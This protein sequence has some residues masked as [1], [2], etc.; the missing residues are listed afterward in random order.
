MLQT[1]RHIATTNSS[2]SGERVLSFG[3]LLTKVT[4]LIRRQYPVMIVAFAAIVGLAVVY[5]LVETPKYT[6]RAILV[7]DS[8]KTPPFRAQQ[9]QIVNATDLTMDTSGV[10]TQLEILKS[11]N[12]ALAVIKKLHLNEDPEFVGTGTGIMDTVSDVFASIFGAGNGP[13]ADFRKLRQAYQRFDSRLKIERIGLTYAME[14]KFQSTSPERAAQ[15]ANAIAD[16]YVSDALQAKYDTATRAASW[17]QDRLAKLRDEAGVAQR[18]VVDYKTKNNIVDSGGQLLNEQQVTEYSTALVQA[19]AQVAEA[20]ARLDRVDAIVNNDKLD[21]AA[22]D[23]GTVSDTLKNDVI[24]HLRQQYADLANREAEWSRRY[25]PDH[26]ANINLRYQM[27]AIRR[28]IVDELKRI[29][30]TYKSDFEIAQARETSIQKG[31]DDIVRQ[32][33]SKNQ[34]QVTLTTLE[35]N[36]QSARTLYDNFVQRYMESV[37][38]QSFAITEARLI[39][40]ATRPLKKSSPKTLL[41]LAIAAAGGLL[42]SFAAG[43]LHDLSDN[44]FRTAQQVEDSLQTACLA[45]VPLYTGPKRPSKARPASKKDSSA[46]DRR[47]ILHEPGILSA[48]S[49]APLSRF[50][51]AIR[52]IKVGAD[53]HRAAKANRVI[54]ITS[55][56]ANE[57][58]STVGYSLAQLVAQGKART[59]LVDCDLRNPSLSRRIAPKARAGIL[60]V[61]SGKAKFDETIWTD[62]ETKLDFLPATMKGRFSDTHEVLASTEMQVLFDALRNHYD[63]VIVD[64]SPLSPVVDV[65][66]MAHLLD[67]F[68][69]VVEWGRTAPAAVERALVETPAVYENLSGVVLNK[70]DITILKRYERYGNEYYANRY[71][72]EAV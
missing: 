21:P 46:A 18:A 49:E 68:V 16:A 40:S 63:E 17:L 34:A 50:S 70:A 58:K 28:S 9:Q 13:D 7:V 72:Q 6:G 61:L 22:L 12:V 31:L 65:R 3:D 39:T 56:L 52:S 53:I 41:V 8:S 29:A 71:Y 43:G 51:E 24:T 36:A 5:V 48:V 27:T 42:I 47:Q 67:T 23:T 64:L 38:Q 55:A 59:I 4:G 14:I 57:G 66:A 11:E 2:D 33:Q 1:S 35:S 20:R 60:E 25:G 19:K 44:T 69:L 54:G 10:D 62:P 30:E 15:V 37:Q 26:I 45:L 32:T